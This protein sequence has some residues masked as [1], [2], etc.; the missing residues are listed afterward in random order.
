MIGHT[1]KEIL[2]LKDAVHQIK[3]SYDWALSKDRV[4]PFFFVIGAGVSVPQV[5]LAS[6]II[7]QCKEK[8][9]S[10]ETSKSGTTVLD[11][12]SYW[13]NEAFHAPEMRQDYFRGLIQGK[14]IPTANFRLAHL[15]LGEGMKKPLTSVVVTT[16]FDNFLSRAL[17]LFGKEYVL[18][19]SPNTAPRLVFSN[20][21]LLQIIHV[22]GSYQ[23]YDIKN[24][25]G[26]VEEAAALSDETIATIAALLDSL[27]RDKSPIV[28]GNG[29][30]EGDVFMKSLKRR[31]RGGTLPQ[32]LYWCCYHPEAWR[33]LPEWL[34]KDHNVRFVEPETQ[35]VTDTAPGFE[36]I[37]TNSIVM[38]NTKP[39]SLREAKPSRPAA[40]DARTVFDELIQT[41][42]ISEPA[43]TRNPVSFFAMQLDRS[44]PKEELTIRTDPYRI[45]SAIDEI[46]A[47]ASWVESYRR[48][49]S[50]AQQELHQV[51]EYLRGVRY[52]D[53]IAAILKITL[54][55][56]NQGEQDDLLEMALEIAEAGTFSLEFSE[57]MLDLLKWLPEL[58]NLAP[59]PNIRIQVARTLINNAGA[60]WQLNRLDEALGIYEEVVRRF[61]EAAEP[62]IRAQV[63]RALVNKGVTLGQ[64]NRSEDALA[65]YEEVV[66][67]FGEAAEPDIRTLVAQA[68]VNKGVRLGQL[69]RSEDALAV[70]EEVVR[71]FGEAAEPDIRAQVA[72]AL[73]NKGV[74]LGQLNRSEDEL[75]RNQKAP[76]SGKSDLT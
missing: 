57:Q 7:K 15:L 5:P 74:R 73:F 68:L 36:G 28:V 52:G 67:R 42:E 51:R 24:L 45:K 62:D 25:S 43:L 4:S 3:Q 11:E 37:P 23:F 22:H 65:V 72:R 58:G 10:I 59:H 18:C 31:L 40:L 49:R 64:L 70:Y 39:T 2:R 38:P 34:R 13:L 27:L 71:R 47:A 21:D 61:G 30:W 76:S 63:A 20:P 50:I 26:E 32:P 29:G 66:R 46:T 19:D 53:A 6:E 8:C 54:K 41:L 44:L 60:L 16:N 17:N 12:Y 48:Q 35:T 69:N 56:L 1:Q 14:P 9:E 33:S 75:G 55:D